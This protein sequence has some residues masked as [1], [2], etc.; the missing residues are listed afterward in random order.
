MRSRDSARDSQCDRSL[1]WEANDV[2]VCQTCVRVFENA[3]LDHES[4]R[5]VN[6]DPDGLVIRQRLLVDCCYCCCYSSLL[7]DW[8]L[9]VLLN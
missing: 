4:T 3:N 8:Q 5:M 6:F 9:L 7:L 1:Q 2:R